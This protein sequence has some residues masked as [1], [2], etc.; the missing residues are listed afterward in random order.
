MILDFSIRSATGA[1][2]LESLIRA[3]VALA[4]HMQ[5]LRCSSKGCV[6]SQIVA[7]S[8]QDCQASGF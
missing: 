2:S 8:R 7:L 3:R 4:G 5:Q 6:L 1:V